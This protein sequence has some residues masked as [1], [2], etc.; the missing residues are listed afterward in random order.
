MACIVLAGGKSL[1]LGRDKALEKLDGQS[2]IER[3]I[4]RLPLP[5]DEIIVVTADENQALPPG[6]EV[7]RVFDVCP[8]RGAL[9]GI[10]SGLRA[11]STFYSLV[12]ACDMPFLN[13]AL[14]RYMIELSPGFDAVIP[15]LGGTL[16][17]LHAVYSKDC[18]GPIEAM[19]GEDRRKLAGLP[20]RVRA[21][22]VGAEE[23]EAFDPEHLSFF[24]INSESDLEWARALIDKQG[25]SLNI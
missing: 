5:D 19:L 24:N 10:Y 17:P 9:V 14:L 3:V 1:R 12:V 2:M 21:R 16:Q 15:R 11:A 22:Y 13:T 25:A 4:E 7:K 23:V 8:G 6:L 20:D 18:L